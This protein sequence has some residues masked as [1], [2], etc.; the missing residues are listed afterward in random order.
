MAKDTYWFSHDYNARSD[1]KILNLRIKHGM[2]GV[3]IYWSI[4]EMLYEEGG[5]VSTNDY[6]RIVFELRSN[7][8]IIRS[9]INDFGLFEVNSDK[10]WSNTIIQRLTL[11]KDKSEQARASINLR[12]EGERKRK[13]LQTN[14]INDTNVLLLDTLVLHTN[15][16]THTIK[17]RKGKE[18][19]ESKKESV[20]NENSAPKKE[21]FMG[22]V[23]ER[24]ATVG[25]NYELHK[26]GAFTKYDAWLENGWKDLKGN[27]IDN[28][29]SKIVSNLQ[30]FKKPLEGFNKS[31]SIIEVSKET[32]Y[33]NQK[34]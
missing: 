30:Y 14:D 5:F 24:C 9:V 16:K 31:S 32:N 19:K 3:G 27:K 20:K 18:N 12:W 2:E 25:E 22:Y 4:V 28:W 7:E 11:R 29:K 8:D 13:L 6:V 33:A 1:G 17:E 10:F 21:D 34:L 26:L 15:S 23:Q